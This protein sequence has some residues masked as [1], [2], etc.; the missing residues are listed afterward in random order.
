VL[1]FLSRLRILDAVRDDERSVGEL[2]DLAAI[3][4]CLTEDV[5]WDIV[6]S[7]PGRPPA[8]CPRWWWH[9]PGRW[10]WPTWA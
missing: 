6:G 2:V 7:S 5:T 9:R 1:R 4:G 3:L 10:G 8:P